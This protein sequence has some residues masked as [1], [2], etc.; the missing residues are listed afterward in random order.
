METIDA[1]FTRRSIRSFKKDEIAK[2]DLLLLVKAAMQAPSANNYQPW[3]FVI[4]TDKKILGEI[5]KFHPYAEML[6]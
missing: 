5:A 6:L 3:H 1:I 4:I 2:E